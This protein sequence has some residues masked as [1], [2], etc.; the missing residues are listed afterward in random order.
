M[1]EKEVSEDVVLAY[2]FS[3]EAVDDIYSRNDQVSMVV[4]FGGGGAT[5]LGLDMPRTCGR[6]GRAGGSVEVS[7]RR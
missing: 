5:R 7:P 6:L 4:C 1:Q 3:A 2:S